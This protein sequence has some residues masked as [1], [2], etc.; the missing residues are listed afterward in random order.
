MKLRNQFSSSISPPPP[1]SL[2]RK[3]TSINSSN[4]ARVI[5]LHESQASLALARLGLQ[6]TMTTMTVSRQLASRVSIE[7]ERD[8]PWPAR[9]HALARSVSDSIPSFHSQ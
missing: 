2:G 8:T 6:V 1:S 5:L 9:P 4:L 3:T 7:L